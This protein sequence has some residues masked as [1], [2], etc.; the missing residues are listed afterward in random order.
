ML[1]SSDSDEAFEEYETPEYDSLETTLGVSAKEAAERL[2]KLKEA[3][4]VAYQFFAGV[5]KDIW[6]VIEDILG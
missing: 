2:G 1:P 6:D 4:P 5:L 3:N